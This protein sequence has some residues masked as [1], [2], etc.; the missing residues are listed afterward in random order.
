MQEPQFT[1]SEFTLTSQQA[2]RAHRHAS[3]LRGLVAVVSL[4]ALSVLSAGCPVAADLENPQQY[5]K[6][7]AS[8]LDASGQVICKPDG[9]T[10]GSAS[11]GS[12]SGGSGTGGGASAGCNVPCVDEIFKSATGCGPCHQSGANLGK[13][14]LDPPYIPKL[15][16]VA[17]THDSANPT[18]ADCPTGDKL[19][20]SADPTKSWLLIKLKGQQKGCGSVMPLSGMLNATQMTCM[21]TFVNCVAKGGGT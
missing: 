20:D 15:K 19:I 17:A 7:G 11:G 9:A 18:P 3:A 5:C 14:N 8:T 6:P 4:A 13:F 1:R 12:A 10:G 21:E 2:Q 16:D